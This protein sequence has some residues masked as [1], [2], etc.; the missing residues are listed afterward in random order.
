M[1]EIRQQSEVQ[2]GNLVCIYANVAL[3][4]AD[5]LPNDVEKLDISEKNRIILPPPHLLI[6]CLV[7]EKVMYKGF[8]GYKYHN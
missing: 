7:F 8:P 3:S 6:M 4:I 1:N 5:L 2:I